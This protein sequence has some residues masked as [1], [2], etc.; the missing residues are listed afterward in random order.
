MMDNTKTAL[1]RCYDNENNLLYIGIS[2][3]AI[4]R[5]SQHKSHSKWF[6][7]IA[8]VDVEWFQDRD[9]AILAEMEAVRIEQP[10]FNVFLKHRKA[11]KQRT[12]KPS[13]QRTYK[14]LA[15]K[16][17]C[18]IQ[19]GIEKSDNYE[20]EP[21]IS[22]TPDILLCLKKG[23]KSANALLDYFPMFERINAG[24]GISKVYVQPK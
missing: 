10:K 5:L 14:I 23:K 22:L 2:L 15:T 8:K 12:K 9:S 6:D 13:Q 3:S 11:H 18:E 19:G 4:N 1:Y 16:N 21:F 24:F 7:A 20:G 17:H